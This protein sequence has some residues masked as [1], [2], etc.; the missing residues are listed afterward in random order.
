MEHLSSDLNPKSNEEKEIMRERKERIRISSASETVVASK[1]MMKTKMEQKTLKLNEYTGRTRG[2]YY[3]LFIRGGKS[4]MKQ[5][6]RTIFSSFC[7]C[8]FF[9]SP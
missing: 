1:D 6:R 5:I 7:F 2:K 9:L 4:F 8:T 3:L